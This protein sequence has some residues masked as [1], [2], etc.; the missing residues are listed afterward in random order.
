[1]GRLSQRHLQH[2]QR[3]HERPPHVRLAPGGGGVRSRQRG[4]V[5]VAAAW[6]HQGCTAAV[7]QRNQRLRPGNHQPSAEHGRQR[8]LRPGEPSRPG[9]RET[10]KVLRES[11]ARFRS[12]TQ[13]TSD[14]YWEMDA[15]LRFTK[16]EGEVSMES[17]QRSINRLIGNH[18]WDVDSRRV[19][20][21]SM[22]WAEF[23]QMLGKRER[24]RD[25]EFRFVNAEEMVYYMPWSG[26]PIFDDNNTFIGYRGITRNVTERKRASEHIR[27]LATHD[28]LIQLP[29]RV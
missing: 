22:T 12:L 26:E 19:Q 9:G 21:T 29:N 1:R 20:P 7:C 23:E 2:F 3:L 11:E 28:A 5:P 15:S 4:G 17:N 24:F 13:L 8:F 18:F 16:Y 27:F 6:I 14:F 10:V 25:F